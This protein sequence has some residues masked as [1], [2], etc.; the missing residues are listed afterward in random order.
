VVPGGFDRFFAACAEEFKKG[1]PEMPLLAELAAQYGI[2]FQ[3]VP[4]Y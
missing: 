1:E 4:P 3:S 2:E